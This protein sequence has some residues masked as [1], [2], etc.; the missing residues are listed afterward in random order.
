MKRF[1]TAGTAISAL[2]TFGTGTAFALPENVVGFPQKAKAAKIQADLVPAFACD[3]NDPD[4]ACTSSL[5]VGG[6]GIGTQNPAPGNL[7]KSAKNGNDCT[8]LTGTVKMQVGKDTQVQLKGVTCGGVSKDSGNLC[9]QT[10]GYSTLSNVL[11]DKKGVITEIEPCGTSSSGFIQGSS[12]YTTTIVANTIT[13]SKGKCKGAL[14][15]QGGQAGANPCP[16][17]DT[18]SEMRRIE[19]FDGGTIAEVDTGL[20]AALKVCCG[21]N[22]QVIPGVAVPIPSAFCPTPQDVLAVPG[23]ISRGEP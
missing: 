14:S 21:V 10:V 6:G 9:G 1:V 20:G 8:F 7:T 19:V 15:S 12:S 17:S 22:Q 5:L 13:C 2:L 3:E 16:K 18:V 23:Q 11:I 4:P